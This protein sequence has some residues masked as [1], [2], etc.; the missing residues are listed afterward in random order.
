MAPRHDHRV[1]PWSAN[2]EA[3]ESAAEYDLGGE[4]KTTDG[5]TTSLG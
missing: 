3:K 2:V 5:W 1:R 4:R